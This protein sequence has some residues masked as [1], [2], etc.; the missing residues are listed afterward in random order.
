MVA[1]LLKA[2]A[3]CRVPDEYLV[4]TRRPLLMGREVLKA[5]LSP[6]VPNSLALSHFLFC[7]P[8]EQTSA[9]A[10]MLTGCQMRSGRRA[11]GLAVVKF[12]Q[13]GVMDFLL[14]GIPCSVTSDRFLELVYII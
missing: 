12:R 13:R 5:T 2:V 4:H 6:I 7:T 10:M 8:L 1:R 9:V 3:K 11:G 14:A